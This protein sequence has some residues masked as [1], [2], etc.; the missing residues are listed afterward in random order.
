M[1]TTALP[2]RELCFDSNDAN[3]ENRMEA[4]RI[5]LRMC[6]IRARKAGARVVSADSTPSVLSC[7][8]LEDDSPNVV[9]WEKTKRSN[10]PGSAMVCPAVPKLCIPKMS[11][12]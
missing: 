9:S 4:L 8:S 7:K 2:A 11:Q 5:T 12:A 1:V 3:R 10:Q 6:N